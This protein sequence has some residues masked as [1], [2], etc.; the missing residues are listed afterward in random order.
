MSIIRMAVEARL[1][2]K[3]TIR[4]LLQSAYFKRYGK[5]MP[6]DSLDEDVKKWEAGVNNI[7]YLYDFVLGAAESA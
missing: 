6:P 5:P 2:A 3:V 7:P 4:Q 1:S